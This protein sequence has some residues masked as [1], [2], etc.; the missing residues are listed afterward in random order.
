MSTHG[1]TLFSSAHGTRSDS[2]L[3][4]RRREADLLCTFIF[5]LYIFTWYLV[6]PVKNDKHI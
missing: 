4:S 6:V 3:T 5:F 2:G 1:S